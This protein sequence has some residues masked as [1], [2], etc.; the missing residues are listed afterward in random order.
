MSRK[1]H[2]GTGAR[3]C[4]DMFGG[5]CSGF[6]RSLLASPLQRTFTAA[7]LDR[8]ESGDQITD[9][10]MLQ[11]VAKRKAEGLDS[12]STG[13]F[14]LYITKE[15]STLEFHWS[16]KKGKSSQHDDISYLLRVSVLIRCIVVT[17]SSSNIH[18]T[19]LHGMHTVFRSSLFS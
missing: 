5:V 9:E 1:A 17:V 16:R 6:D 15:K 12:K 11:S 8:L 18:Q 19:R 4:E 10:Q 7:W 2:Q 13:P 14:V 3:S